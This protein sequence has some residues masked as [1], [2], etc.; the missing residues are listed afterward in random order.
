MGSGFATKNFIL[1]IGFYE[2]GIFFITGW[3]SMHLTNILLILGF[4]SLLLSL[5]CFI[6]QPKKFVSKSLS[7]LQRKCENN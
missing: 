7:Y 1:G 4:F 5:I 2:A 6:E 3:C